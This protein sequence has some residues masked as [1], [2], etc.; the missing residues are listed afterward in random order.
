LIDPSLTTINQPFYEMGK[1]AA[2]MLIE[3][4]GKETKNNK[5][6]TVTLEAEL[7]IRGSTK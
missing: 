7:I 2:E 4:I 6:T 1:K 5:P 3:M